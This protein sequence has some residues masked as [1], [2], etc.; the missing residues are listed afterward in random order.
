MIIRKISEQDDRDKSEKSMSAA[1]NT[2]TVVFCR[3]NS[4]NP[5]TSPTGLPGWISP[6]GIRL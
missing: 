1:G 2:P 3:N 6:G 4:L 5:S